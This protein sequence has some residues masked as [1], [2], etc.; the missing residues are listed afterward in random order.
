M[1][2][3]SLIGVSLLLVISAFP[4]DEQDRNREKVAPVVVVA[5]LKLENA[6]G[7]VYPGKAIPLF[8]PHKDGLFRVSYYIE[9]PPSA[10]TLAC[11]IIEWTDNL[12]PET[13]PYQ[14]CAGNQGVGVSYASFG[15]GSIVI[16][17]KA[18]TPI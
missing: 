4:Q 14:V 13:A 16:Y 12:Q 18:G 6:N 8:T 5:R 2:V 15:T 11:M 1:R 7:E 3:F 10:T 9:A 17:A